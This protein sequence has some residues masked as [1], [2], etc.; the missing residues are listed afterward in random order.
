MSD[1]QKLKDEF[2]RISNELQQFDEFGRHLQSQIESLQSYLIE[3]SRTKT[4]LTGLKE[5]PD[6]EEV[7]LQLGSGVMVRAKPL[8]PTKVF[9]NVGAGVTISK[10]IEE[11]IQDINN[12]I[13]EVEKERL[14]LADQLS[15]IISQIN[16][17]ERRAQA[18]YQQ[19][20]GASKP[21]YDPNLVS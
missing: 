7:L 4:T 3:L 9:A 21:T 13:D 6:A 18:I 10:T 11:A 16:E 8:E 12:R 19:L 15:Q 20:Q 17:R 14:A 2:Q 1:E 5:E